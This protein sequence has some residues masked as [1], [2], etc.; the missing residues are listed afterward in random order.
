MNLKHG[1][2]RKSAIENATYHAWQDMIARCADASYA[3]YGGRGI[4]VCKRWQRFELFLQDMG[5]KPSGLTL[6]RE[7][8]S[9]GYSSTNKDALATVRTRHV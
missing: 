9:K 4:T 3:A 2:L 7:D 1:H 5:L 8:N 6:E